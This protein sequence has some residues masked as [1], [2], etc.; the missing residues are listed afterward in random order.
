[1]KKSHSK[2]SYA[3]IRKR[4]GVSTTHTISG[5]NSVICFCKRH[6]L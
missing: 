1:M 3:L 6:D 4:W 2:V 5:Y